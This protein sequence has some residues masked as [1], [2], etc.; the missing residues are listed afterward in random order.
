[1]QHSLDIFQIDV[2]LDIIGRIYPYLF[3][4]VG[5]VAL[6]GVWR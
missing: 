4:W 5:G 2:I 3:A 1:M 6:K